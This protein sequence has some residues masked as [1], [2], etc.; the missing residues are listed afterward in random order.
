MKTKIIT[1]EK[2]LNTQEG[3]TEPRV[4]M[5]EIAKEFRLAH[6]LPE[7]DQIAFCVPK[8]EDSK[9]QLSNNDKVSGFLISEANL[10]CWVERGKERNFRGRLGIAY[11]EKMQIE[12][13]EAGIGSDFYSQLMSSSNDTRLHHL[14]FFVKELEPI[15]FSLTSAGF[16][17]YVEGKSNIGAVEVDF[18]Y[19]DTFQEL[20]FYMEFICCSK[21]GI[22]FIPDASLF[23]A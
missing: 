10:P 20:G 16:P 17:L 2:L 4:E 5:R 6:Q 13:L 7:I 22:S 11:Y 15:S 23:K 1:L 9:S 14:G 3:S 12:F 8:V 18:H 21:D 19:I